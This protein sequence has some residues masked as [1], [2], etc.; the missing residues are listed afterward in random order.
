[1]IAHPSKEENDLEVRGNQA[2]NLTKKKESSG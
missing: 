2:G 1:M